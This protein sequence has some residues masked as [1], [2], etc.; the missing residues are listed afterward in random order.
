[1]DPTRSTVAARKARWV[2]R[3]PEQRKAETQK[4]RTTFAFNEIRRQIAK[5][6]SEQGLPPH[7][8]AEKFLDD[9]ARELLGGGRD[10]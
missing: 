3:T 1:V 5:A 9:L 4:A 7:V 6:R 8:E 2:G 10:A